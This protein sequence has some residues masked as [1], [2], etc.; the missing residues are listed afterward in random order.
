MISLNFTDK[1]AKIN[2][3]P[4]ENPTTIISGITDN[5]ISQCNSARVTTIITSNALN[6]AIKLL[7]LE[8]I[9]ANTNKYFG[10]YNKP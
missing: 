7:K 2:P 10:T 1:A 8:T 3:I 6:E 4:R 5:I 9:L